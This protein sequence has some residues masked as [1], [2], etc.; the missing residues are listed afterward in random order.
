[1]HF[2]DWAFYG[3]L[4]TQDKNSTLV[5]RIGQ[6]DPA[7]ALQS[8]AVLGQFFAVEDEPVDAFDNVG[9][10]GVD[11][12][13]LDQQPVMPTD[14]QHRVHRI[15]FTGFRV[16]GFDAHRLVYDTTG[17]SDGVGKIEGHYRS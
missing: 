9:I 11:Q 7:A 12:V 3:F 8:D 10:A 16:D 15:R 4:G 6:G 17:C 5:Q 13:A 1:P 2:I 14:Q